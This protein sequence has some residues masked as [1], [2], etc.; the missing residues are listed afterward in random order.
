M[1]H[2]LSFLQDTLTTDVVN[3]YPSV[4][5]DIGLELVYIVGLTQQPTGVLVNGEPFTNFEYDPDNGAL[6][7]TVD[8]GFI[9]IA[10]P[11]T[12]QLQYDSSVDASSL[13]ISKCSRRLL[14]PLECVNSN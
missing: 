6:Y 4:V 2:F 13:A 5:S 3:S 14:R 8:D 10:E 1:N 11:L 12:I 7:I 9:S